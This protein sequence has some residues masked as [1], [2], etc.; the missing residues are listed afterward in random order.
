MCLRSNFEVIGTMQRQC[1]YTVQIYNTQYDVRSTRYYDIAIQFGLQALSPLP[2]NSSCLPQACP[3]PRRSPLAALAVLL[4]TGP[5][6]ETVPSPCLHIGVV[7]NGI[8]IDIRD[9][10]YSTIRPFDTSPFDNQPSTSSSNNDR[11]NTTSPRTIATATPI[12][13]TESPFSPSTDS[14]AA[15]S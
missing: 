7:N 4:P 13:L 3:C 9:F 5:K 11:D 8:C 10:D 1:Q 12:D 2:G 15:L 14:M 6:G